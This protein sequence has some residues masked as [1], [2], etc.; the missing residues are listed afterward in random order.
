MLKV[1]L[2]CAIAE[3]GLLRRVCNRVR[4]R[5]LAFV[6]ERLLQGAPG[7]RRKLRRLQVLAVSVGYQ[8]AKL[9]VFVMKFYIS[10]TEV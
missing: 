4:F 9:N 3:T 1:V 7:I 2:D 6:A 8:P 10:N 5:E